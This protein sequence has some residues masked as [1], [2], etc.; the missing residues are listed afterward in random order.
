MDGEITNVA[1]L[2]SAALR[3]LL[4][5]HLKLKCSLN[6]PLSKY[7]LVKITLYF[8]LK[9]DMYMHV[10]PMN[11]ESL[12][13]MSRDKYRISLIILSFQKLSKL[14]QAYPISLVVICI[15]LR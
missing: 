15:L 14:Y 13:Y 8:S 12:E 9:M 6:Q 7:A 11:L 10:A 3:K 1:K 4:K 5:P 2:E